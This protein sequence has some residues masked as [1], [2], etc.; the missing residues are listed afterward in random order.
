LTNSGRGGDLSYKK[1]YNYSKKM[2]T[3][4]AKPVRMI[5]DPDNQRPDKWSSPVMQSNENFDSESIV[6]FV[7]DSRLTRCPVECLK[8]FI[9]SEFHPKF[10]T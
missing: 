7:V 3:R 6:E 4:R 9:A 1:M 10:K 2:F 8:A 5:D